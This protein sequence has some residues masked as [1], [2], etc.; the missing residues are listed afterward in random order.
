MHPHP[1]IPGVKPS[2]ASAF[3]PIFTLLSGKSLSPKAALGGHIAF[4]SRH[5][6]HAQSGG[7]LETAHAEVFVLLCCGAPRD[8]QFLSGDWQGPCD[9]YIGFGACGFL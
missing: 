6:G 8:L 7:D 1:A 2:T 9:L 4:T 5:T 3:A